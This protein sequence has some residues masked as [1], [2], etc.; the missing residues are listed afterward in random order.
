MNFQLTEER[1]M[2][3]DSLRRYLSDTV[4]PEA[5]IEATDSDMNAIDHNWLP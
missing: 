5:L 3:Q 1:Q 2:L 4:S